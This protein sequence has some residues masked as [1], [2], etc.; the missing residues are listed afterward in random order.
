M[1]KQLMKVTNLLLIFAVL[2]LSACGFQLRGSSSTGTLTINNVYIQQTAASGIVQSMRSVLE[3]QSV[4]LA[5][6]AKD[7]DIIIRLDN[8]AFD[9]RVLSVDANT[10]KVREFELGYKVQ[11]QVERGGEQLLAPVTVN[12]R[13]DYVFDENA[14]LGKYQEESVLNKEMLDAAARQVIRRVEAVSRN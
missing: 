8:E 2:M 10:G 1:N 14:V 12:Q 9:R 3:G 13:R 5:S 4:S 7:A 6:S 11:L